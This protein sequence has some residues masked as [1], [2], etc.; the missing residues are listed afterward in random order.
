MH[1]FSLR[2]V[3]SNTFR[4]K[5]L[6]NV[7]FRCLHFRAGC[8][9]LCAPAHVGGLSLTNEAGF[10]GREK[11][12]LWAGQKAAWSRGVRT[13]EQ[14]CVG[15]EEKAQNQEAAAVPPKRD[16]RTEH[17][18]ANRSREMWAKNQGGT[19]SVRSGPGAFVD[20]PVPLPSLLQPISRAYRT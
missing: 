5:R 14:L 10:E 20:W 6:S 8:S 18:E 7:Y 19:D 15:V 16:K 2:I 12:R 9:S 11:P 1:H 17:Q 13:R 4:R 3:Y